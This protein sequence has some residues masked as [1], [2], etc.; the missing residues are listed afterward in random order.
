MLLVTKAINRL[1]RLRAQ[2]NGKCRYC[3]CE[4]I[5]LHPD[6]NVRPSREHFIPKA[7]G[8]SDGG[9]NI[10]LACMACNRI[11]S[12]M[13]GDEYLH[14]LKTGMLADTYIEWVTRRFVE[15]AKNVG[16]LHVPTS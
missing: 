16:K 11:K 5:P 8:G 4:C 7:R 2:F 15:F 3:E 10:V 6:E 12:D 9:V 1:R 14:F 13:T